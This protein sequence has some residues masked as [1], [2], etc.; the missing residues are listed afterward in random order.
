M[1]TLSFPS[2]TPDQRGGKQFGHDTTS[3]R[4]RSSDGGI[5]RNNGG[6][7]RHTVSR[8]PPLP[9]KAHLPLRIP[10]RRSPRE[11][12]PINGLDPADEAHRT[13]DRRARPH[14]R[15]TPSPRYRPPWEPIPFF[16]SLPRTAPLRLASVSYPLLAPF[17]LPL[18]S[19]DTFCTS[20]PPQVV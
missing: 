9:R 10:H 15:R 2:R 16:L 1:R 18:S 3:G 4:T 5:P 20:P 7:C 14:G 12:N 19:S 11:K 6:C 17:F 13:A 8:V